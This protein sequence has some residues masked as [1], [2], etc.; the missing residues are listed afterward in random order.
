MN[1]RHGTLEKKPP[2]FEDYLKPN[3][4]IQPWMLPYLSEQPRMQDFVFFGL[5]SL[6]FLMA[7]LT[8]H[9]LGLGDIISATTG[10]IGV[11]VLGGEAEM[12]HMIAE[13]KFGQAKKSVSTD[14]FQND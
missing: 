7:G 3:P 2:Q 11:C 14:K 5:V 1:T 8:F 6:F 10:L 9:W 12:R 4:F 13:A